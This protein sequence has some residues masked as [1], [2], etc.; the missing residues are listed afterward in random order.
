MREARWALA[1]A[2]EGAQVA[3]RGQGGARTDG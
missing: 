1:W 3:A 2:P